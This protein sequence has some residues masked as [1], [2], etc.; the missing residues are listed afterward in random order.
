MD[1]CATESAEKA[2]KLSGFRLALLVLVITGM[3]V[4][5]VRAFETGILD[6]DTWWHLAAG[7]YIAAHQSIPHQDIFSWTV[8][9]EPWITHE[10]LAEVLFYLAYLAGSFWGVL[11]L[12]L[13]LVALLFA[14]Y[15]KLLLRSGGRYPVAVLSLLVTGEMLYPFLE[16]RP[17]VL[18]Y[19]FFVIFLYVL[20]L[21]REKKDYLF[22][23]PVIS[24]LWANSH[25]SFFLG[26]GLAGLYLLTGLSRVRGER[27][28]NLP[29]DTGQ[30]GKLALIL[31]LCLLAAALNPNGFGLLLYPLGTVGDKLMTDNIQEWLSLDF[32]DLYA[33]LFLVY[34]LSVFAA[35]VI[36]TCRIRVTD[37]VLY[38]L[39]GAAAFVHGRFA[40][41]A[42]LV[43]G[44]VLARYLRPSL[45]IKTDLTRLK[46]VLV[47]VLLVFYAV[48]LAAKAPPQS[49]I[50]YRFTD[51]EDY[52]VE[53][54]A[55]LKDNPLDGKVLNNYGWGGY[56]IWN[57][58]QEK[59]FIDGRADVYMKKVFGDYITITRLR[60]GAAELLEEYNIKY[61]FMPA[62]SPLVQALT[63]SPRWSVL[64]E[65]QTATIL[66]RNS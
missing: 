17:Q 33:Q 38:L 27:L 65:D 13:L 10:W 53:A 23:L 40:A 28:Q 57:L 36:T 18:S 52:P 42:L 64:Y 44:F 35:M 55:F 66:I 43:G 21:F 62:G 34:Y 54:V 2:E 63:L 49:K 45:D 37:L 56:L 12:V 29:W 16:I 47:P 15:T 8:S 22:L 3:L 14:F 50:D 19:L 4:L 5:V 11:S 41:Y 51:K 39:F 7:R 6:P 25:G 60:P 30:A 26:P 32:H 1:G 61:V 20:E 46:A 48:V 59:V 24:V 31:L 9:G 58:P